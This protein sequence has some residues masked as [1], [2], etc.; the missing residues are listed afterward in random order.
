MPTLI[1]FAAACLASLAASP[2]Q[3]K[4]AP[5]DKPAD[6]A[7]DHAVDHAVDHAAD[8]AQGAKDHAEEH[9]Q[10]EDAEPHKPPRVSVEQVRAAGEV[11]GLAFTDD[12]LSLMLN[13]VSESLGNLEH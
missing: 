12:E 6:H 9:A 2:L 11:I 8:H 5:P 10:D 1:A 13:G 7:A 4:P 3:E